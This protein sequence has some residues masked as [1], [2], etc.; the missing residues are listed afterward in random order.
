MISSRV[1]HDSRALL[2]RTSCT[3]MLFSNLTELLLCALCPSVCLVGLT[4]IRLQ[5]HPDNLTFSFFAS[6]FLWKKVLLLEYVVSQKSAIRSQP[7]DSSWTYD[8]P[9]YTHTDYPSSSRSWGQTFVLLTINGIRFLFYLQW[10]LP[11]TC[12]PGTLIPPCQGRM[13]SENPFCYT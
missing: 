7:L 4:E 5:P 2:W 6:T 3:V 13:K 9:Q 10:P 1:K 8:T 12:P 11:S